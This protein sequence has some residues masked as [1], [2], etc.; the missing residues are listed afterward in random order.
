MLSHEMYAA[1]MSHY[2]Y[3]LKDLLHL[4]DYQIMLLYVQM[5]K[6]DNKILQLIEGLKPWL[7]FD[8]YGSIVSQNK[9]KRINSKWVED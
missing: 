8:L 3:T 7:N 2:K 4:S 6:D 1:V 5:L 9:N